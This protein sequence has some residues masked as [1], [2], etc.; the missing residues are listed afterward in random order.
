MQAKGF[1]LQASY[2]VQGNVPVV[3]LYGCL[4]NGETFL[5]R[6]RRPRPHFYV[7]TTAAD[8]ARQ[9]G[10]VVVQASDRQTFS[11]EAVSRVEVAVPQDAPGV[12]DRLH[13]QDVVTYEADVR[14]A[15]RYLIDRDIR[16]G[17]LI[18]GPAQ[19]EYHDR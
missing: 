15:V 7:P 18:C 11:G 8:L 17:C 4:E 16:G 10:A 1:I 13:A 2:R 14:Y 3:H 19:R 9:A 5:V 12:R 6:D